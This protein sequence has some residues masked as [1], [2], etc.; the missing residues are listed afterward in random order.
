MIDYNQIWIGSIGCQM[1]PLAHRIFVPMTLMPMFYISLH[2]PIQPRVIKVYSLKITNPSLKNELI[3]EESRKSTPRHGENLSDSDLILSINKISDRFENQTSSS[4][5]PISPHNKVKKR[6]RIPEKWSRNVRQKLRN[7]GKEYK[8]SNKNKTRP[9]KSVKAACTEKCKLRCFNNFSEQDRQNI[10]SS[11]WSLANIE[12]QRQFIHNSMVTNEPRYRYVREGG[13]RPVRQK[14]MKYFF[15]INENVTRVC[16]VFFMNTLNINSRIIRTVLEKSNKVANVLLE[17]DQRGK[18][19]NQ[20]K[21]KPE[22]REGIKAFIESI[23][24][25]ES[26]YTRAHSSKLFID[27]SKTVTNLHKDYVIQCKEKKIEYGNYQLFYRIFNTEHNISFFSPKKDQCE[28]CVA[29]ENSDENQKNC[30]KQEYDIHISEKEMSRAEKKSDKVK[31][32]S[33]TIVAVYDMQAVMQLP[34]GDV[35]VFYYKSKLN[36]INFTIYNMIDNDCDCFVWDESCA[37]RGSNELGTC[38][39]RFI[40]E[41]SIN[42]N[43]QHF[44]FYS[45]NCAGQQKNKFMLAIYFYAVRYLNVESITHKYLIK[46]HTQNEGDSVHSL[47]ERNVKRHLKSGPI[48]TPE[49]FISVIR[50]AKKTGNPYKVFEMCFED[51]YDVKQLH[52]DIGPI[53]MKQIKM[54]DVKILKVMQDN[55]NKLFYKT[56]YSQ[57]NFEEATVIKKNASKEIQLV[58]LFTVK[59]GISE[60]KKSGLLE[61]VNKNLI[62]KYYKSFY[63]NL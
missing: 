54:N 35:S 28:L 53:V 12:K 24:K 63:E 26:H 48:Y 36:V 59:P 8:M 39:L 6:Q 27:G 7:S 52:S 44:V 18:H 31:K 2:I 62:P 13:I 55:P 43:I 51:F 19:G 34:K 29:Y 61:L 9:A 33:N 41:K 17:S 3:S 37:N 57:E 50:N 30:L 22:I 60:S 32:F 49:T 10:F 45:D 58:Q 1:L 42:N 47:I 56:S 16:K 11:Y 46:G 20:P 14:N 15:T 23:P 25:I 38:V 4:T 40:K 5:L 21:V